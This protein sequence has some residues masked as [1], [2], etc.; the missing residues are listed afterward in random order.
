MYFITNNED[1]IVAASKSLLDKIGYRDICSLSLALKNKEI[2]F[3]EDDILKISNYDNE[4]KYK[5][6]ELHSAFGKLD[7]YQVSIKDDT[8]IEDDNIEYLKKIK[9]G[10]VQTQDDEFSIPKIN[11][12]TDNEDKTKIDK[13][14]EM[15]LETKDDIE[16]KEEESD[17]LE[18][19]K[20][21]ELDVVKIF[22]DSDTQESDNNEKV[23]LK[24][25]IQNQEESIKENIV[26]EIKD[27]IVQD[28]KSTATNTTNEALLD[29][30]NKE[31][32]Q[33]EEEVVQKEED[34]VEKVVDLSD[35]L[36]DVKDNQEHEKE[37]AKES[38]SGLSKLT[39]KLFPWGSKD[40]DSKIELEEDGNNIKTTEELIAKSVKQEIP[41]IDKN[42]EI[43]V[44]KL[45]E[46]PSNKAI[47]QEEKDELVEIQDTPTVKLVEVDEDIQ[48]QKSTPVDSTIATTTLY[49]LIEIQVDAID[50]EKN[51]NKLSIDTDNYKLLLNNYLDEIENYKDDLLNDNKSTIDMLMDASNLLSLDIITKRLQQQ[52]NENALKELFVIT[53]LIRQKIND[54]VTADIKPT[55][56]K[57]QEDIEDVEIE[58]KEED[59]TP[60][61][62]PQDM[63]DITSSENLLKSIKAQKVEFN[64]QKASDEL[65][66]PKS[67]II[68]FVN[69]FAKQAKEHLPQL[70]QGYK[71]DDIRTLQTTAHMLKGAASNLRL[72]EIAQTLFK[73]QKEN[74]MS[75]S[76]ELIKEFVA[77]LKGLENEL[78]KMESM[79]NED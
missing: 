44:E 79:S 4:L 55:V 7:L 71:N 34:V 27:N 12:D 15:I 56:S 64:P 13:L 17:N 23:E 31:V 9:D 37:N 58:T 43:I 33:E 52:P 67:L 61:S 77:K 66:L 3:I 76:G 29:L 18:N 5:L 40:S 14:E 32:A 50:I 49:K 68:E 65:N 47:N 41:E 78:K 35:K 69:D 59:I 73:I 16:D 45:E 28:N 25:Y 51:S 62:I 60:P 38:K 74:S 24:D 42:E 53:K 1:F 6:V 11:K 2:R 22:G 57:V 63:I 19:S 20:N 21:Q 72:D 70:V 26:D 39:S 30:I 8:Q 46:E 75:K 10:L 54:D 48:K 36:V